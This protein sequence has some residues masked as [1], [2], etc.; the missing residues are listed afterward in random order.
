MATAPAVQLCL[1]ARPIALIQIS[2]DGRNFAFSR[3]NVT[4]VRRL[5]QPDG[6][7]R[8]VVIL[9]VEDEFLIGLA[10]KAILNV[11][12]HQVVGPAATADEAMELAD[13]HGPELAFVD[14]NIAGDRDGV[15][16]AR[17]LTLDH[18]TTCIFVTARP[19]RARGARDVAIG[20]VTKPYDPCDLLLAVDVAAAI[21]AGQIAPEAS[22]HLE[23]FA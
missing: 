8:A 2:A 5:G 14:I 7:H 21:R 19:D 9:I 6:R 23:L 18:G 20:V 13:A 4:W 10:L 15:E 3:C 17:A 1:A 22:R 12:G 11:V 16:V